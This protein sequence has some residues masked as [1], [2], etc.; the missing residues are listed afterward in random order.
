M[1]DPN[2]AKVTINYEGGSITTAVGNAKGIFGDTNY[3]F[4]RDQDEEVTRSVKK[5]PRV[6][7]IG[8]PSIEVEAHTYTTRVWPRTARSNSAGGQ[9]IMIAW[10][11]SEGYWTARMNGTISALGTFLNREAFSA[12]VVKTAGSTYGPFVRTFQIGG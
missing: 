4:I 6:R 2:A 5:H 3:E 12:T 11:G 10:E 7:V 1:A 9:E 8:G